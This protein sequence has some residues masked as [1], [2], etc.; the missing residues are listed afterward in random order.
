SLWQASL[1]KLIDQATL[2]CQDKLQLFNLLV[3]NEDALNV[4]E[5]LNAI[6][7][8]PVDSASLIQRISNSAASEH[9]G[10]SNNQ[11]FDATGSCAF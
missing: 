4:S 6:I 5:Q 9:T 1:A 8:A 7:G 10:N 11:T 2:G 3:V